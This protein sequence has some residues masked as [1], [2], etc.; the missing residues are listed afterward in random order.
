MIEIASLQPHQVTDVKYM[1]AA[2]AQRIY[3]PEKTPQEFYDILA[4]EGE[5][6][7]VDH[8]QQIYENGFGL[9]L[10]VLDE[11]RVIGSGALKRMD[12]KI[13]ELKRLW[14]LEEYHGQGIGY[15]VVMQLFDFARQKGYTHVRLQTGESQTR[16]IQFYEKLGFYRVKSYRE[17]MDN[18]SMEM[19]L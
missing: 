6:Q 5:L 1:I 13:A 11:D 4:E 19:K 16:A 9:F 3:Y 17:S 2:V 14:L 8:F 15:R 12:E 7:D 10:V 18:V